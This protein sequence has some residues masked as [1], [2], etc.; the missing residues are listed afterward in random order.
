M[1]DSFLPKGYEAPVSGSGY[2]KLQ[3][4]DNV[5]RV[6]SPAIVGYEYWT[7]D[8]KPV[9]SKIPFTETPDI[10]SGNDGKPQ[11]VKHFWAFAIWNY[12]TKAV[13]ILQ[14]TQKSIQSAISNLVADED[15]GD[16]KQYD[17][18][19]TRTG[20]ELTTEYAVSP[21]P[22]KELTV[23]ITKEYADKKINLDALYTGA[24]PFE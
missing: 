5:I 23:A 24:N 4:G 10:K 22:K 14:V 13:E 3:D 17:I 8:N 18:K 19:I 2:T 11:K 21:K 16:P 1:S 12:T 9:R 6:M 7:T 20:A 15:W